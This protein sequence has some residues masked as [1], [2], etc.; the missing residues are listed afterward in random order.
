MSETAQDTRPRFSKG[1]Q[2]EVVECDA[3]TGRPREGGEVIPAV[4]ASANSVFVTVYY[5]RHATVRT[6]ILFDTASGWAAADREERK[7]HLCPTASEDR[8][9]AVMVTV[10][11]T[12]G[13]CAAYLADQI[14]WDDYPGHY[15]DIA[16]WL[17]R[18][19]PTRCGRDAPGC[20]SAP[21][22]P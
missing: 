4:I 14:Q 5:G 22:S 12:P 19:W 1:D 6:P 17:P 10:R 3:A 8:T 20:P 9:F 18:T 16:A 2:V 7:W 21:H 15:A 11:M 13:Q